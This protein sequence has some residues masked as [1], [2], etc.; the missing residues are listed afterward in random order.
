MT[1]TALDSLFLY[2]SGPRDASIAIVGESW[3]ST[4]HQRKKPFVGESGKELNKIL[5]ECNLN[6]NDIFCTNVVPE[7][8]PS[9]RNS[10]GIYERS[11]K[12]FFHSTADVKSFSYEE[13]RGLYPKAN[14]LLGLG[15]LHEQLLMVNPD[16]II[17]FGNYALWALTP[18]DFKV[19]NSD[20]RKVPTGIG[21]WRGSQLYTFNATPFL[22]T[23]HPAAA[24]RNWPWRTLIKHDISRRL[25]KVFNGGWQE[26]EW[27]FIIRPEYATAIRYLDEL[28]ARLI[29][30]EVIDVTNDIETRAGHIACV[31]LGYNID[32]L[33]HTGN[34][35][36][37]PFMCSER[38]EGYWPE[39]QEAIIVRML[40]Y[41]FTHPNARNIGQNF[42]FD[43]QYYAK[44][45][46]ITI[47]CALDT[48]LMHHVCWPG[49]PMGLSYLSSLYNNYH[50]YWKDEGAIGE[51]KE[52]GKDIPEEQLWT[53]NCKDIVNTS[54]VKNALVGL[55]IQLKLEQQAK[56]QMDQFPML[57]AMQLRGV[58]INTT[59]RAKLSLE[60]GEAYNSRS[61]YLHRV[62]P[63]DV[64][65]PKKGAKDWVGSPQQQSELFYDI[66]GVP[67]KGR[68]RSMDDEHLERVA[69]MQPILAKP[70]EAIQEMR[71]IRVFN[72]NF[73]KA[74]LDKDKRL[75]C[76]YNPTAKTFR[77]KSSENA[78]GTGTNLQNIP[79]GT[80]ED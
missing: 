41:I 76:S 9:I 58:N 68:S 18:G 7:L 56:T 52:W 25:P 60:L 20:G 15:Q 79:A 78:F 55:I 1:D 5:A 29:S 10:K 19:G 23:Y 74:P 30:G 66:L 57:L 13:V 72:S 21:A 67:Q 12:W 37:I 73:C 4:E 22:P 27:D 65:P 47:S 61:D 33:N 40:S 70:V 28:T 62:I 45:W 77:Y 43:A 38:L 50:C 3:G 14:V 44:W 17:G 46:G 75:R 16:I 32:H 42:L 53:Y 6:R 11:M 63:D 59:L 48:M 54:E 49:T 64:M 26:P 34:I 2:T 24:M 69:L 31:G 8:P 35:I 39:E 51:D 80:E 71:S 36:C